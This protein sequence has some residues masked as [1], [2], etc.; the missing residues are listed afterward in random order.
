LLFEGYL[1]IFISEYVHAIS[2]TYRK[3]SAGYN[4]YQTYILTLSIFL[5]QISYIIVIKYIHCAWN[6][7]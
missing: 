4:R 3:A 6:D 5:C 1:W 7:V 2:E